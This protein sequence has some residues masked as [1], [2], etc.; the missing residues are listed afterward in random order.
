[1]GIEVMYAVPGLLGAAFVLTALLM[2]LPATTRGPMRRSFAAVAAA[3]F[4]YLLGDGMAR[5]S[6]AGGLPSAMDH[7]N[8]VHSVGATFLPPGLLLFAATFADHPRARWLEPGV[9]SIYGL[10]AAF[11]GARLV[12]P[13]VVVETRVVDGMVSIEPGQA[14]GVYVAFLV[15]VTL[16]A[17]AVFLVESRA[18]ASARTRR[19]SLY[20][21]T[22]VGLSLAAGG[23]YFA[24]GQP[25][26]APALD[27]V[28]IAVPVVVLV[29]FAVLIR[30]QAPATS[31]SVIRS[32]FNALQDPLLI[33][34]PSSTITLANDAARG[35]LGSP[36][37]PVEGAHVVEAL[38]APA[39]SEEARAQLAGAVEEVASGRSDHVAL[40]VVTQP[41]QPRH[42]DV[43]VA[44]AAP[45]PRDPRGRDAAAGGPRGGR[46]VFIRFQDDTELRLKEGQLSKAIE[47]KDLFISMFGHDLSAPL[48]AI[49]GYSELVALDSQHSSDALAVY[50]YSLQIRDA[51][52]QI[53]L[54]MENARVFSRMLDAR[55]ITSMQEPMDIP[56]IVRREISNLTRAAELKGIKFDVKVEGDGAALVVEASPI[57]RNVFQ[58]LLDNA[59]KYGPSGSTVAVG[60]RSYGEVVEVDIADDGPG[61]PAAKREDVFR[62]FTRLEQTRAKAEGIG[63]GLSIVRGIVEIHGGTVSITDREDGSP[64]AVFVV[65]LP[66]HLS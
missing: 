17:F 23:A 55:E 25:G 3:A 46:S 39:F 27:P 66:R 41:P 5:L 33:V 15:A 1:M 31:F 20:G 19:E 64:G 53:Q 18:A 21:A 30:H 43:A 42:L 22:S 61:V 40:Q 62:K 24:L 45:P 26:M 16:A 57:I 4:V 32:I 50:K 48:S 49:S 36:T 38:R 28:S 37:A 12:T 52:A 63:I 44:L 65:R 6:A 35:L 13:L 11:V 2:A 34:D 14:Y 8:V 54:M 29:L 59:I 9:V 51:A 47:A 58:N 60:I 7:W 56:A 10:A